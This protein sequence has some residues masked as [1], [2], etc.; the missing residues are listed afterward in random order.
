MAT[1]KPERILVGPFIIPAGSSVSNVCQTGARQIVGAIMPSAWDAADLRLEAE[2]V[3]S[4]EGTY[5]PVFISGSQAGWASTDAVASRY[6]AISGLYA[7]GEV[8]LRSGT[9]ALPVNQTA[10]RTIWL[11]VI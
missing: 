3:G 11:V 10:S 2:L 6:L 5:G 9:T 8:R 1:I 4:A 7:L